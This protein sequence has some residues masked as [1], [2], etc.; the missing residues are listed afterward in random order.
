MKKTALYLGG[1]C[2]LCLFSGCAPAGQGT[3][4]SAGNPTERPARLSGFDQSGAAQNLPRGMSL[5]APYVSALGEPCY[6]ALP[7]NAPAGAGQAVCLRQKEWELLPPIYMTMPAAGT[8]AAK[9]P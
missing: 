6:E 4:Y 5:G 8:Q 1:A 2:L 9:R 7:E 3:G